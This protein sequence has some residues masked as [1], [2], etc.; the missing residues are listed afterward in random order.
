MSEFCKLFGHT[1][2]AYHQQLRRLGIKRVEDRMLLDQVLLIR[3]EM[4]MIGTRK[5]HYLL[6]A[7]REI[8]GI[9]CGRDLPPKN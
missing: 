4:P 2:Q 6:E 3:R 5:L 1:R 9:K 8:K 7:L